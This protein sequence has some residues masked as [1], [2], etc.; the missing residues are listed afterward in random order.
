[1]QQQ[2]R[3]IRH[4]TPRKVKIMTVNVMGMVGLGIAIAAIVFS[5]DQ[6]E[7]LSQIGLELVNSPLGLIVSSITTLI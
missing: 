1:M 6:A 2:N 5:Q 4:F 7:R 3:V